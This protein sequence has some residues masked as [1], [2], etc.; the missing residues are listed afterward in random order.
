MEQQ[1]SQPARRPLPTRPLPTFMHPRIFRIGED[2]RDAD[3]VRPTGF[4][5]LDRE[6]PGG[7]WPHAGL[8]EIGCDQSG[9][10]ELSLLL[11]GPQHTLPGPLLW[12]LP[13]VQ[14]WIPYAPGLAAQGV[15]LSQLAIARTR[16]NEDTLWVAE[17]ALRSGA[18]RSV[19]L[20]LAGSYCS[21]LRLRRLLQAALSGS[22]TA[23]ALRPLES[24]V[25]P[26]PAGLRIGLHAE[27]GGALRLDL[28]KRRGLPAG[29]SVTVTPRKLP[30]LLRLGATGAR[31]SRWLDRLLTG[32][33][34]NE[35][36]TLSAD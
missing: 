13:D 28:V 16:D 27:A 19:V 10:G 34:A 5:E 1:A 26:S 2:R 29:K 36:A 15:E 6:L 9:I 22:C 24:L 4:A 14:P 21:S 18:C 30:C 20:W 11:Q 8:I 32:P 35:T 33:T 7:G 25:A 17:Q 31:P 12:V 23:I 3:P